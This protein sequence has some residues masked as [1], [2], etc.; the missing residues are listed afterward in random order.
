ML[1]GFEIVEEITEAP[2][3]AI[4]IQVFPGHK[5]LELDLPLA[6]FLQTSWPCLHVYFVHSF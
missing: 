1:Q 4:S 6:R 3:L 5:L 2:P